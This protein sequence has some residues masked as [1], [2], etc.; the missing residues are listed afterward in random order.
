MRGRGITHL[1]GIND[2]ENCNFF[3]MVFVEHGF[4]NILIGIHIWTYKNKRYPPIRHSKTDKRFS[5][6]HER[7]WFP[8]RK[9]PH[10][11]VII[12][13]KFNLT[14]IKSIDGETLSPILALAYIMKKGNTSLEQAFT[15][16]KHILGKL[17]I[18]KS[19][20]L[21]NT[22]FTYF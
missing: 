10:I 8:I 1:I 19:C 15:H 14:P 3:E 6:I 7:L 22:Y 13:I 11:L 12:L 21:R 5:K 9:S 4:N 18:N 2:G 20:F 16:V 17:K